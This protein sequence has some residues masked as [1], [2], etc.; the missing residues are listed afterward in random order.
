MDMRNLEG[1]VKGERAIGM[2]GQIH[3]SGGGIRNGE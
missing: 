2:R 1:D 3:R